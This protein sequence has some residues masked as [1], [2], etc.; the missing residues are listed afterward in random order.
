MNHGI[1]VFDNF[2]F[3]WAQSNLSCGGLNNIGHGGGWLD[4]IDSVEG[5]HWSISQTGADWLDILNS[6]FDRAGNY[7]VLSGGHWGDILN[8]ISWYVWYVTCGQWLGLGLVG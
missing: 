8:L 4:E 1:F 7:N 5:G 3:W 6:G 2:G